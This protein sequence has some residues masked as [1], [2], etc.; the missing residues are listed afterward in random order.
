MTFPEGNYNGYRLA[1]GI[2]S[3]LNGLEGNFTFE[4]MY[5]T[6]T[7]T[8]SIEETTEGGSNTFEIPSDYGITDWFD[9]HSEYSWRN[10][11]NDFL[12]TQIIII[13][14]LLMCIKKYRN[15]TCSSIIHV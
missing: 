7:G 11:D 2:Q 10:I 4:V 6:A 1:T 3:L 5:N 14:N 12:Y 9:N 13:F 8:I 15:D